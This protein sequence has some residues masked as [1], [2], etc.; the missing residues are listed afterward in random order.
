[1]PRPAFVLRFLL[2]VIAPIM[3]QPGQLLVVSPGHPTHTL[4]VYHPATRRVVRHRY[5]EDGAL[6]GPLLI[7]D[8]DGAVEFLTPEDQQTAARLAG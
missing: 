8:A 5:V 1:M 7:L 6:Y 2:P 3:G 4:A